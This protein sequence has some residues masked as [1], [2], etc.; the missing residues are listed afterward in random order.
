M[1]WELSRGEDNFIINK[2]TGE[3]YL[4]YSSEV[5]S[6]L[7]P[8]C[9]VR[10]WE[11]NNPT[12]KFWRQ[13]IY[14]EGRSIGVVKADKKDDLP[15]LTVGQ[16][17]IILELQNTQKDQRL[18]LALGIEEGNPTFIPYIGKKC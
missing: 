7:D 12:K 14:S 16:R 9:E 13:A 2:D 5:I 17:L 18:Y 8:V 4:P 6:E 11:L 15:A 1:L 10:E 3:M